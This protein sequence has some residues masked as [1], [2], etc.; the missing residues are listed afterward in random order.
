MRTLNL[1][2][3]AHVDAGKTSLTERL[4]YAAGVI[5]EIGS[6]DDGSTQTDSLALERRRGITIKSAVVSFAVGDV[7]G[8]PDR[9]AR[10]PGLHR[11]GGTGARRARRRGAGGV[12]GRGRAGADPGAD[13][14]A[15]AA[16]HPDAG[17]RQQDRPAR[18]AACAGC[19]G[20]RGSSTPAVVPMGRCVGAGDPCALSSCRRRATARCELLAEHDDALLAAYVEGRRRAATLRAVLAAQ[21]RRGAGAPGVLRLGDHRRGGATQLV[22]GLRELLPAPAAT[23]TG[24]CR[25]RCS[26]WSAARPAR[27]SRYVR[28][29]VRHGAG[30]RPGAFGTGSTA[31]V[32]AIGV[33]DRGARGRA[34]TPCR[35][36]RI[37]QAVG[38]WRASGSGTR[39]GV[40]ARR[41]A[42]HRFA[43]PTLE[44]VV[45]PCA[46]CRAG[47]AARRADAAGR[48]GPADRPAAG[49][50]R[51]SCGSRCTA[52]CRRRSSQATL[53]DEYGARGRVPRD[54]HH[55]RGAA[56]RG[57]RGGRVHRRRTPNPFLATVG[58]R[59][60]PAPTARV[61][62]GLEVELGSMPSAFFTAVEETVRETL[63]QG[64][65]GWEV[66]DCAVTM[67]HCRLLGRGRATRTARSTR[68]C[69]ARQ[70]T[71][72]G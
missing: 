72:G 26:R 63:R 56:G 34:V 47:R 35:A 46:A 4:L 38:A 60:E 54:H 23:P 41:P 49:R 7:D 8:Q 12:R 71:S 25:A 19:C 43:P 15:A 69:R 22:A 44:T 6:V 32:T 48:A 62:F 50:R 64:L 52:R 9:H 53:A 51:A 55:L 68:A 36:G 28:M 24:R 16:A 2:I 21:T 27:G 18:R 30:A 45:V 31:K 70:A 65:Y 58:L 5:D 20:H 67:T 37:A 14:G 1:G 17:L 33:F 42:G 66:T 3:L 13:A 59:V 10:P 61:T 40:A 39:V 11:R 29:F 57:R